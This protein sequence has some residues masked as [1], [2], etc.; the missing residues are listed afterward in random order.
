MRLCWMSDWVIFFR[1]R[2]RQAYSVG[3]G[4]KKVLP[5][6]TIQ[7]RRL[8]FVVEI[9]SSCIGDKY[10]RSRKRIRVRRKV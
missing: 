10:V 2:Q 3:K 5:V 7:C 6:W 4:V 9:A 8:I 1:R